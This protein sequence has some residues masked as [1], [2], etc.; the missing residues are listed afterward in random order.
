MAVAIEDDI[1]IKK[2][3]HA[4]L[5]MQFSRSTFAESNSVSKFTIFNFNTTSDLSLITP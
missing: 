2:I 3:E 1:T 4:K 5:F